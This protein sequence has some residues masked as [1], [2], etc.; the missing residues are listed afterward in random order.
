MEKIQKPIPK[1][2]HCAL[3]TEYIRDLARKYF[4]PE[5]VTNYIPVHPS[6]HQC[7]C[8]IMLNKLSY[9][10]SNCGSHWIY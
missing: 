4:C 2:T 1:L 9:H 10:I 6:I 8:S 7:H 3:Q 5:F